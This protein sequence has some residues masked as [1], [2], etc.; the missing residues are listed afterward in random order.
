VNAA[1][2]FAASSTAELKKIYAGNGT[3]KFNDVRR[4][5]CGP[6]AGFQT[7]PAWDYCTGV[8]SPHALS[9]L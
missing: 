3:A 1:G 4:G 9:G 7:T 8:G 6:Y 2:G 5:I